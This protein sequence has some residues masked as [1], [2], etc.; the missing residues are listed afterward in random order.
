MASDRASLPKAY[1]PSEVES[2]WYSF[3]KERGYFAAQDVSDKPPY[4]IVIPPPNITGSLHMGHAVFVT[5]QDILIRWKRMSGYNALWLPGTDHAGIATQMIVER[6]L[7]AKEG[8]SR[9]DLGREKFLERVWAWKAKYGSRITEQFQVLGASLDWA[10]ERFTLDEGLSRAVREAFVRLWEEGLI[11]RANRLINW[12]PK[13]RTALSDLEVDHEEGAQGELFE[14][15]YPLSDGSGE[16]VVATT[17]PETMLGDTA[18]A[19][20]PDDERYR[21]LIGK[22]VRHPFTGEEIPIVADAILVDPEFGTGAV[23]ITPAHDFNDFEVGKRHGLPMKNVLNPDGTL[24]E[25]AGRFAGMDRFEARK[26]VKEELGK[27]GLARGTRPHVMALGRCQRCGTVVEPYLSLQWFVKIEPLARPAIEAVERGDTVFIPEQ[28]TNTYMA[29]MRDIRDWCISRQL[30]WGH[31]IPAFY[32]PDGHVTVTRQDPEACATCGSTE[33]V[34][35]EDVLDTWFSSG[36]WPFSTLGWPDD[37]QA[38]RTFYPTTVLETGFDIIF[39]WVARMMMMGL[40]FMGEVPF[41]TVYLHPMV[42]DEKGEKMSKTKGNVIDPLEVTEKYGADALRFTLAAMTAQGRD[43]KL[44][45]ERV[46]GYKAFANKIWNAAR[47]ALLHL[48]RADMKAAPEPAKWSDADRWIV[49]RYHRAVAE[50]LEALEAF[51]FNEA[52]SRVYQFIWHE[53]CDWYIE[54]VKPRL[55][56][57]MEEEK[58]VSARVL[59]DVLDGSLR[60]LHPFMPFVTEEIWQKLPRAEGDPDSIMIA[61]YPRPDPDL[62][63]DEAAQRFDTLIAWVQAIRSLRVDLSI[64]EGAEI[65]VF[66]DADE[67]T[68]AWLR[69]RVFWLGRL[70][71]VRRAAP[72]SEAWPERSPSGFVKG[73]EFRI[74]LEG[75]VNREELVAK[76]RKEEEKLAAE[77]SKLQ[78][79]LSNERFLARA[80]AE[81]VEKDRAL[82]AEQEGRL[83]R[84]RENISML[85]AEG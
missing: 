2:R 84:I 51:R 45:L 48:D 82:A 71:K 72:R 57:G 73:I 24:N 4:C 8:L 10:R 6:E 63:E 74:A 31:R 11:Y 59:R 47:F 43:I 22:T 60:L 54:L 39:F 64:P 28:W 52:T 18:V 44:S 77:L 40:H 56:D 38:L 32:C 66:F 42:R 81:V 30:W 34:Q 49:S 33:L 83:Q 12:C 36:L 9:H 85:S 27:L 65:E 14:F 37:T 70:A 46:A 78:A 75:V 7:V 68:T 15:A 58:A 26:A 1:E 23:K 25:A 35:D 41:R 19:V 13:D 69:D 61:D 29:W 55:Y 16:I 53:L 67:E 20:H 62:V 17:R 5:L 76:L 79:R 3:W 80:P 21:H 50:T